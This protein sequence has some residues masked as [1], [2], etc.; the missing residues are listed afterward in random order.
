MQPLPALNSWQSYGF[1]LLSAR[2]TNLY[3]QPG[4]LVVPFALSFLLMISYTTFLLVCVC[5]YT[6]YYF[7]VCYVQA[8]LNVF[9]AGSIVYFVFKFYYTN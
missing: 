6:E 3:H 9:L 5:F 8:C 1:S 2:I 7:P 4:P